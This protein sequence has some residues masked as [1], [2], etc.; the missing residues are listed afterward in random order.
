MSSPQIAE[1]AIWVQVR[2]LAA[3]LKEGCKPRKLQALDW[4]LCQSPASQP[5]SRPK[6]MRLNLAAYCW[7]AGTAEAAAAAKTRKP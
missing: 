6:L 5:A 3:V 7:F 2:V 1:L 4:T